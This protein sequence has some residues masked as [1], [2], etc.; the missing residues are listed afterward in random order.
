MGGLRHHAAREAAER[1]SAGPADAGRKQLRCGRPALDTGK[2]GQLDAAGRGRERLHRHDEA[3]PIHLLRDHR[4][5]QH[6]RNDHA[7]RI[8]AVCGG[9]GKMGT[10]GRGCGGEGKGF[11][12]KRR[13]QRLRLCRFRCR[14]RPEQER[15]GVE[16][17]EGSRFGQRG[18]SGQDRCTDCCAAI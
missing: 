11:G 6:H 16:G 18:R 7:Q 17:H 4:H 8:R 3:R 12:R 13:G 14:S 5:Q 10:D 9:S 15:R 2:A 1:R